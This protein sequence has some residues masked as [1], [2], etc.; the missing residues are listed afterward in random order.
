MR[1]AYV[2]AA[3]ATIA[4]RGQPFWE[5]CR[6]GAA[7]AS[8][9]RLARRS[10]TGA[11]S[12]LSMYQPLIGIFCAL[13]PVGWAHRFASSRPFGTRGPGLLRCGSRGAQ[14]THS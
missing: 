14:H 11:R 12:D 8:E 5:P 9:A 7:L 6:A 1:I 13:W 3:A 2:V 10:L 4:G